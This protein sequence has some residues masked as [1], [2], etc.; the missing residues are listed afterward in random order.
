MLCLGPTQKRQRVC[1][2]DSTQ[3]DPSTPVSKGEGRLYSYFH[4]WLQS[5]DLDL[6]AHSNSPIQDGTCMD[7][8]PV[9]AQVSTLDILFFLYP[10]I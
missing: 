6:G 2:V 7:D 9:L 4:L 10:N 3:G 8:C 1:A 5:L